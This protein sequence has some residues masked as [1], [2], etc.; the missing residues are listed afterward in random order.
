MS[1]YREIV[2]KKIKKVSSDP[3]SGIDGEMWY[4]STT[5]TLR[6]PAIV[7]A[8]SSGAPLVAARSSGAGFGISTAAVYAGGQTS[9]GPMGS[10][11]FEYNGSGW[12]TGGALNTARNEMGGITAGILTA[13]LVF[14]GSTG[15][16]WTGTNATEEYNGTAWTSVNNLATTVSFMGGSGIQT[17]AFSAGGRTPSNTNNS[18]EYDGSNWSNGN[19][20]NST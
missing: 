5:G 11:T 10:D 12:A 16:G 14:G 2:G 9:P 8:W 1:T 19:N 7:E 3:S 20:I 4:N 13:G 15:P 6:G 17:A 18:Q